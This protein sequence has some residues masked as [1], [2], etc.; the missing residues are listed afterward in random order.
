MNIGQE[1]T[2]RNLIFKVVDI[3]SN[4]K[5]K[6]MCN[7]VCLYIKAQD[8]YMERKIFETYM[9]RKSYTQC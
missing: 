6:V 2:Y 1:W 9:N 5:Y 4:N 7:D 8:I 3:D